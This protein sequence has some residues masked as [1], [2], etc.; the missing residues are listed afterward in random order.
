MKEQKF[1][2]KKEKDYLQI[3]LLVEVGEIIYR[4]V[5]WWKLVILSTDRSAGGG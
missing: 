5:C 2:N 3:G 1:Q 4:Q